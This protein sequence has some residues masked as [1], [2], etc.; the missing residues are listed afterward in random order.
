MNRP[1]AINTL[2]AAATRY[3][4]AAERSDVAALH[5]AIAGFFAESQHALAICKSSAAKFIDKAKQQRTLI[6]AIET[7]LEPEHA[8]A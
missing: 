3:V 1:D 6:E 4:N 5:F 8:S 7:I 2:E